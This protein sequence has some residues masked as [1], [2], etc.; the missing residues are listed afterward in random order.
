MKQILAILAL[1]T[2]MFSCKKD[3]LTGDKA[4]FIGKWEWFKS[5]HTY[6]FCTGDPPIDETLT[7]DTEGNNYSIEFLKK[8][9]IKFYENGISLTKDRLV[10]FKFGQPCAYTDNS[11]SFAIYLDNNLHES[12]YLFQGCVN[13]DTLILTRGFP[14]ESANDDPCESYTSYFVKQ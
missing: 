1:S 8:G 11:T 3:K 2:L 13:L 12:E 9:I 7:P 14:Y 6:G 5:E 4:I 10:F